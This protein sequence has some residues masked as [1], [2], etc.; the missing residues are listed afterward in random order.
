MTGCLL[1]KYETLIVI[2]IKESKTLVELSSTRCFS[3]LVDTLTEIS[4]Q[5]GRTY[6]TLFRTQGNGGLSLP[7]ESGDYEVE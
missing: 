4:I 2:T 7:N 5:T 3:I 6:Y 1:P